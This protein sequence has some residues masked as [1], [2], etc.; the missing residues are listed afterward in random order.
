M[1]ERAMDEFS[2]K[3][4]SAIDPSKPADPLR[5]TAD[6]AL[7]AGRDVQAAAVDL[8]H[9]STEALKGH[10]SE[11]AE[12]AKDI[13]SQAGDRLQEKVAEQKGVGVAYVNNLADTMRRAAGEF[14]ADIPLAGTYIR[15]AAAR[16][17]SAADALREGNFNDLVRGAQSFARNQPTAFLGL[18]VL[19]GFGV[20][21]F[22]KSSSASQMDDEL[23][24]GGG[25]LRQRRRLN[26][27]TARQT[28][29]G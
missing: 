12:A 3:R 7:A 29:H 10:A 25:D 26:G 27:R 24:S 18:A 28:Y 9:S 6:K 20:V 23:E 11:F 22:L 13:A 4:E 19:A 16:V 5:A 14:D 2:A 17:E 1:Q 15:K 8:A 21:R